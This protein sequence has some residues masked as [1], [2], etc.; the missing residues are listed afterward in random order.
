MCQHDVLICSQQRCK[1]QVTNEFLKHLIYPSDSGYGECMIASKKSMDVPLVSKDGYLQHGC[2][3][4]IVELKLYL[5][6][7]NVC[8]NLFSSTLQH[9][10]L[11]IQHAILQGVFF[12]YCKPYQHQ[13]HLQVKNCLILWLSR[14]AQRRKLVLSIYYFR[15]QLI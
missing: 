14:W 1:L 9:P 11:L 10:E 5:S 15:S 13:G 12:A 7:A 4:S 8:A 6:R 3:W 2:S